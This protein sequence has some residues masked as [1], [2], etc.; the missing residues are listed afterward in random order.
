MS[1]NTWTLK[2]EVE[3]RLKTDND[4]EFKLKLISGDGEIFGN[5]LVAHQIYSFSPGSNISVISW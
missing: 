4:I 5:E 1:I 2:P 3:L